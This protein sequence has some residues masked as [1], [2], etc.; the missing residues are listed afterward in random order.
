MMTELIYSLPHLSILAF[1]L[2][3]VLHSSLWILAIAVLKNLP[4]FQGPCTANYLW[5]TAMLGG[6]FS[7]LLMCQTGTNELSIALGESRTFRSIPALQS[8]L[9]R[10]SD[11]EKAEA[12]LPMSLPP[13]EGLQVATSFKVN[14]A[15]DGLIANWPLLLCF[16]WILG[17]LILLL[18]MY[19][20]HRSFIATVGLR[21][22]V[23][24]PELLDMFSELKQQAGVEAQVRLSHS[25]DLQ[26]PI[27]LMGKEICLP[28]IAVQEME[29]AH[30]KAMLAHELAHIRRKDFQWSVLLAIVNI[31]FFFQPL[32]FWV[33]KQIES[34]NELICDAR[35]GNYTGNRIAMA[36]CLLQ[37]AE[38]KCRELQSYPFVSSM[39]ARP[40]ELQTRIR[41]LLAAGPE[42]SRG[43]YK[44]RAAALSSFV[45]VPLLFFSPSFDLGFAVS[46]RPSQ[47]IPKLIPEL[48]PP[49]QLAHQDREFLDR[50][51]LEQASKSKRNCAFL[52]EATVHNDLERMIELLQTI[53]ANCLYCAT[54]SA[55]APL[56]AAVRLGH[57]EACVLLLE[58][59]ADVYHQARQDEGAVI[60]A[61]N[62]GDLRMLKLLQEYGAD[63]RD[64]YGEYGTPLMAAKH[65]GMHELVDF[66]EAM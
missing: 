26:S 13:T 27:V 3:F 61:V 21:R 30:L 45:A 39:S 7:S 8:E 36:Q 29:E 28:T 52:L 46:E 49:V 58:S 54:E 12:V 44:F 31:L 57:F 6:L 47:E 50:E 66:L 24:V 63:L 2:T 33:R 20:Q 32:L 51:R 22:Q 48:L 11:C 64:V 9:P 34:S 42:L 15:I 35:A 38:W 56:N 19:L 10:W 1:A 59:G 23:L 25:L 4:F 40:S 53:D 18:R 41:S 65:R 14:G 37:V 17:S 62:N 55:S 5:K 60:A 43:F 16:V